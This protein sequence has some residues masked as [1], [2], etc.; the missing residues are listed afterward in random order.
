MD[1][2]LKAIGNRVGKQKMVSNKLCLKPFIFCGP[3]R[4]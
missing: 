1:I 2:D 3:T 4:T